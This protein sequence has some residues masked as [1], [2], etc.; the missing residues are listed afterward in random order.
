MAVGKRRVWQQRVPRQG[1]VT[2]LLLTCHTITPSH[3]DVCNNSFSCQFHIQLRTRSPQVSLLHWNQDEEC[4]G[5][6]GGD[7]AMVVGGYAQPLKALAAQLTDLRLSTPV[8]AVEY[9][10]EGVRVTTDAGDVLSGDAVIVTVPLGCLKEGSIRFSPPLP[11]WKLQ[12]ISNV[13]FGNLNK[14]ATCCAWVHGNG[15]GCES[16]VPALISKKDCMH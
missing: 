6:F 8:Q 16:C 10:E 5:G 12:A 1:G 11:G 4:G 15:N 2:C 7:H 13:G 3:L 9:T 14:V